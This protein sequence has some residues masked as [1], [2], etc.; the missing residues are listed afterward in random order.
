M[1]MFIS[2]AFIIAPNINQQKLSS[3]MKETHPLSGN[4]EVM[5]CLVSRKGG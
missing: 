3:S 5:G 4:I 2:E 1:D